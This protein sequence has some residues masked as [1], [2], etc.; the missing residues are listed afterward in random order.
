M[1]GLNK[2]FW[3]LV[4][5][6]SLWV[7]VCV[8]VCCIPVFPT[9]FRHTI[10][11]RSKLRSCNDQKPKQVNKKMWILYVASPFFFFVYFWVVR[12]PAHILMAGVGPWR[13]KM[14]IKKTE[15]LK[16]DVVF[17]PF[18]YIVCWELKPPPTLGRFYTIT[19]NDR[20]IPKCQW[21]DVMNRPQGR[22]VWSFSSA[23][24]RDSLCIFSNANLLLFFWLFFL[25]TN[26]RTGPC[27]CTSRQLEL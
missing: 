19:R 20:P 2:Y 6:I 3:G 10:T 22:L 25:K 15:A 17:I 9:N 5:L 13:R 4:V 18:S 26:K 16:C 21:A 1:Y 8:C 27:S 24:G 7:C 14:K 12:N 11:H 23:R